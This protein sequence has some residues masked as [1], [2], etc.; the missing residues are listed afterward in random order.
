VAHVD[1]GV[2]DARD[3]KVG[4]TPAIGSVISNWWRVG[5]TGSVAPRA[6]ATSRAHAPAASTTA[7][8]AIV[9]LGVRTPSTPRG[10]ISKPVAA[11]CGSST[12][13]SFSAARQ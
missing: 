7:R 9:P 2:D 4:P 11:V 8:V 13:P 12:A 6:E 3:R 10:P 5:T 1:V